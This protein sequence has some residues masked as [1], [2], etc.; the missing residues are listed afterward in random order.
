M[1]PTMLVFLMI[2][3]EKPALKEME[4]KIW[5]MK[6]QWFQT[7]TSCTEFAGSI[8][9]NDVNMSRVGISMKQKSRFVEC[10]C[11]PTEL[12]NSKAGTPGYMFRDKIEN[13][14]DLTNK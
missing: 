14:V 6:P 3:S 10:T 1:E 2:C 8:N 11:I 12:A 7:L 4:N 9:Y 5:D 13:R